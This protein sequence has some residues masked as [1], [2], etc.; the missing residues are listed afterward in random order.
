M[1]GQL[2][3]GVDYGTDS[4]RAL[5]VDARSGQEV[6]SGV[7]AYKRWGNGD[8]CD[9][10][11]NQ[12][13]QHPQDY[14]DALQECVAEALAQA[15]P[16]AGQ[17]VAGLS[18]DTTGSTPCLVDKSGRPLALTDSLSSDPDAMFVLWKDH[19]ATAEANHINALNSTWNTDYLKY[20]GG[21]YSSEWLWAKLAKILSDRPDLKKVTGGVIEH[22]DWMPALLTGTETPKSVRRSRC[23]AGHKGLW[24]EEWGGW[25]E[26]GY[27]QAISPALAGLRA[28]L[29]DETYCSDDAV[30][31]I[32]PEWAER[33]GL[34]P[35]IIV[36]V[37]AF[38]CHM[39]AVGGEIKSN[40]L[41]RVIGTSTCDIM[42]IPEDEFKGHTVK[43]ICGQVNGSVLPRY[44]G[45]EAG[46]S[47]FGDLYAWYARLVA[48]PLQQSAL[49][50]GRTIDDEGDL[51][52][53]VLTELTQAAERIAPGTSGV[54]ALD[55]MN[56]RRTPDADQTLK[57]AIAG[58]SM[59]TSPPEIFKG[60]VEASCFGSRAI[61]DRLIRE[62]I[63]IDD[64]IAMGG[65]AQKADMVMQTMADCLNRPIK[66][67]K[68]EQT[69][70]LGAA[71]FASVAAG[72]HPDISTA[73]SAMGQGF[74]KHYTPDP[75]AAAIHTQIYEEKYTPFGRFIETT[76]A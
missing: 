51:I 68:A 24:A 32:T 1:T 25:P 21:I 45:L 55:W 3:L 37:G 12:Y 5:L 76:T 65:V 17:H 11:I 50:G 40:T 39:G 41:S 33:L 67:A 44:V 22:C 59:S 57:G 6:G 7:A 70:A 74:S 49:N 23:A 28:T 31:R 61:T 63:V 69:C 16:N 27:L 52:A 4:A 47:A 18:F 14:I 13:R 48:W 64:V 20:V 19:T 36:G 8:Y 42:V 2:V 62:G 58:L 72:V 34:N 75:K 29:G 73:Q 71:M 10:S 53:S 43:G 46:Q 38:D 66:V 56:G 54:F 60:L 9:E 35:D 30:G 15:G 26:E